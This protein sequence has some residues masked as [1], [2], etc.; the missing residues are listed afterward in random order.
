M[1]DVGRYD[2]E[3]ETKEAI[4]SSSTTARI[5]SAEKSVAQARD[6]LEKA[7]AG[8]HAVESM[9]E[10]VDDVRSRPVLKVSLLAGLLSII[11]LVVFAMM[12]GD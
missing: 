11:G 1:G 3:P 2:G 12:S 9:S 4:M 5:R 6:A 8:L 7:E 10:K